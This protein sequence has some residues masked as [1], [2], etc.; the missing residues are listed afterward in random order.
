MWSWGYESIFSKN[1][2]HEIFFAKN[3][4]PKKS[5]RPSFVIDAM[6]LRLDCWYQNYG[7]FK[8]SLGFLLTNLFFQ[9]NSFRIIYMRIRTLNF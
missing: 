9:T 7:T 3:I 6:E 2:I 1:T 8:Q 5:K 4:P